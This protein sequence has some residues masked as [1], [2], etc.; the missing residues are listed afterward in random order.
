MMKKNILVKYFVKELFVYYVIAFLFF[1]M[2]F[3][4]NQILLMVQDVLKQRV[5]LGQVLLLM[6]YCLPFVIS[7]AAPYATLVGFLMCIA[8]MVTDNEILV[9]RALGISY[10]ALLVS[11]LIMGAVISLGSFIVNDVL[12]PRGAIAYNRLYRKMLTS[13]P[14]VILEPNSVK[15]TQNAILVIGDVVENEVSD[16]LMFDTDSSGHQRIIASEGAVIQQPSD[17]QVLMQIDMHDSLIFIPSNNDYTSLD[18]VT[19]KSTVMNIFAS[20]FGNIQNGLNPQ[21]MTSYDLRK[22]IEKLKAEKTESD[23]Y[24]NIFEVEY[25]RKFALPFSSLFF[26]FLAFPLAIIFGKH[27]GQTVGFIVGIVICLLYWVIQT[28]GQVFGQRNGLN[29]FWAMWLSDFI[30]GFFG[31]IFYVKMRRS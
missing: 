24:I 25:Y 14:S 7:Q 9:L 12:F 28:L 3:F 26:A 1:F 8:R 21:E 5:P 17:S 20:S 31:I 29:A 22:Y 10:K 27:N 18:Y 19:S 15:R 11:V 30:V 16:L 6:L 23:M 13:N 4:V 2:I